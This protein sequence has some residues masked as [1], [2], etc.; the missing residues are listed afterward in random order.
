MTKDEKRDIFEIIQKH[1]KAI[2][3]L[4]VIIAIC[5]PITI[6]VIYLIGSSGWGMRTDIT[7]DGMLG[8]WAAIISSFATIFLGSITLILSNR[9]TK[10]NDDL[11]Q[12][13]KDQYML[14]TRPF[15]MVTNWKAFGKKF[16]EIEQS[17]DK[18]YICVDEN[19]V[20]DQRDVACLSIFLTN[21]TKSFLLAEYGN[22]YIIKKGKRRD[23]GK[24]A[25]NQLNPKLSL[26]P[27]E[28]KEIVLYGKGS[29]MN[30]L[31]GETICFSFKLE[32]RLGD[33][34]LETLDA[35]VL[36]IS[37]SFLQGLG[38]WFVALS[39]NNYKVEEVVIR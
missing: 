26:I 20:D 3:S 12:L 29:F 1:S 22:G 37:D 17:P 28:T 31:R 33:Q 14:E 15:I 23:F 25:V 30:S 39:V 8:Y 21:T 9:N 18:L 32:N 5:C 4:A 38:N 2:I 24:S 27:G 11:L 10:I 34:Y 36:Q 16:S 19:N 6:W 35:T 13:Q 7:A